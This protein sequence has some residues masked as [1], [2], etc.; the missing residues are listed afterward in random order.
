MVHANR[1]NFKS[2]VKNAQSEH[3]HHFVLFCP[4]RI[5][6]DMDLSDGARSTYLI[7]SNFLNRDG[8][9]IASNK[10][11]VERRK[12]D[13]RQIIRHLEELENRGYIWRDIYKKGYNTRRRIWL[14]EKYAEYLLVNKISDTKF[15]A[16]L[17]ELIK[18]NSFPSTP[19]TEEEDNDSNN[20][21]DMS[22]MTG[23]DMSDATGSSLTSTPP[24]INKYNGGAETTSE[25]S[26][27]PSSLSID[28]DT[29][30]LFHSGRKYL[31]GL[32][33][34]EIQQVQMSYEKNKIIIRNP[35]AWIT[36][37]IKQGWYKENMLS[38]HDIQTNFSFAQQIEKRFLKLQLSNMY[39]YFIAEGTGIAFVVGGK[40][41]PMPTYKMASQRF[42]ESVSNILE[43]HY[44]L[45]KIFA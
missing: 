17:D 26:P 3:A 6:M 21:C 39:T 22:P 34:S 15:S 23:S 13:E 32:N 2:V 9:C 29:L 5:A 33:E 35:E 24:I 36:E 30:P 27:P 44:D 7:I 28:Q 40:E 10:W 41:I 43:K 18:N 1:S 37:C 38:D 42:K 11:L 31:K 19:A 16:H 4:S 8:F 25:Q 45:K 20:V 12:Q 14:H